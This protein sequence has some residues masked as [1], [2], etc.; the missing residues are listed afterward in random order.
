M[1]TWKSNDFWISFGPTSNTEYKLSDLIPQEK[2]KKLT[3]TYIYIEPQILLHT[4]STQI[5]TR[6]IHSTDSTVTLVPL[7]DPLLSHAFTYSP[8]DGAKGY[9]GLHGATYHM[10]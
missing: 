1:H 8:Q 2:K 9:F 3:E 10:F 4:L 6:G 5:T 7:V